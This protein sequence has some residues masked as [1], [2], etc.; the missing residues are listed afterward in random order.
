MTPYLESKAELSQ[1]CRTAD[2][3]KTAQ[4]RWRNVRASQTSG[5]SGQ[6]RPAAERQIQGN[7]M[8]QNHGPENIFSGGQD[9]QTA[10]EQISSHA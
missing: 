1:N 3:S 6:D 5:S 4:R 10:E 8:T 7:L 2:N 9:S